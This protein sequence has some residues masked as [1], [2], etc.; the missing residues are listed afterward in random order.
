MKT[1]NIKDDKHFKIMGSIALS[2]TG[3]KRVFDEDIIVLN[4]VNPVAAELAYNTAGIQVR[5]K[6]NSQKIV[7]KVKLKHK[8]NMKNMSSLGQSGVDL[9]MYHQELGKYIFQRST[10]INNNIIEYEQ[11]LINKEDNN[12]NSYIL[13]LPLYNSV[14]EVLLL[15][16]S[17]AEAIP[18]TK[19]HDD[20]I[21]FYG[22]S[23]V[24]GGTVTRAGLLYSNI[25]SRVIDNEIYNFGFSG[26]AFL[27]VEM[28]KILT[29]VKNPKILIID[30]EPNAGVDF[31]LR[32]NLEN[33]IKAFRSVHQHTKILVCS[34]ISYSFD[35]LDKNSLSHN[36]SN[37]EFMKTLVEKL[38]VNDSNIFYIDGY[39]V[40]GDD[41]YEYTVDGVHPNDLGSIALAEFY[42]AEILKH[43]N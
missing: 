26:T 41:F 25:I 33:F 13:N 2:E 34:R 36:H 7:V 30:A 5:F 4:K 1:Y 31:K 17:F 24:Q 3:L 10:P 20:N 18:F 38:S 9:Y 39:D 19:K 40:F 42:L 12:F 21:I 23:I 15:I 32:A 22:S 27:E 16:D 11:E 35:L 37:K 43:L 6:T 29:K 8:S 14:D 28:A